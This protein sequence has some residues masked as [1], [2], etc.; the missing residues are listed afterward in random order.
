MARKPTS[1]RKCCSFAVCHGLCHSVTELF[2][3]QRHLSLS[4]P[5]TSLSR[6]PWAFYIWSI[7]HLLLLGYIVYQFHP[8]GKKTI[9]D[10]VSWRFPLLLVLNSVYVHLWARQQYIIAF[11]FALLVASAVSHVYVVVKK[12]HRGDILADECGYP[13]VSR[14]TF[15]D[16]I[17]PFDDPKCSFIF[18]SRCTTDGR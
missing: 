6:A 5:D 13:I 17:S 11:V 10:G 15:A 4:S 8:I 2:P 18:R 16:V 7:I 14:S 3:T 12:D 9:I 1:R